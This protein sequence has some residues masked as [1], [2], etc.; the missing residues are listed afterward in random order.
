MVVTVV[1]S[2]CNSTHVT[3]SPDA[4]IADGKIRHLGSIDKFSKK[5]RKGTVVATHAEAADGMAV[6]VK[7]A[8]ERVY[9]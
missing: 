8:G 2:S 5:A 1:K 7:V 3:R 9:G 6:A 4:G